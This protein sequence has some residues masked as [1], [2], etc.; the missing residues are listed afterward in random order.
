MRE[1]GRAKTAWGCMGCLT[2]F[3]AAVFVSGLVAGLA[4]YLHERMGPGTGDRRVADPTSQGELPVVELMIDADRLGRPVSPLIY[5]SNLTAKTEYEMDVARFAR[6]TGIKIFRYPGSSSEGYHWKE[7]RFDFNSRFNP[8]PMTRFDKVLKFCRIAGAGLVLQVNIESGTPEEA[9]DWVRFMNRSGK[10]PRVVYWELGNEV[11]GDWDRNHMSGEAYAAVIRR[12][13]AAMKAVDPGIEIGAN[14]AGPNDPFFDEA[15]LRGAAGDIDF[16]S[17]HWYP[18]HTNPE[19]PSGGSKHP[20]PEAVMGNAPAVEELVARVDRILSRVA[21][22]RVG[23]I[24]VA[25]LEWDGS[26]DAPASDPEHRGRGV[27]WSLA[28]AIFYADALGRFARHG[29]ILA[30]Q[31]DFQEGMFGLI[32]GWDR[33][34]GWGG[35]RWD[36]RT[37]RPKALAL[38]LFARHFGDRLVKTRLTG[39]PRYDHETIDLRADAFRGEV[40][41]V[42]AYGSWRT[43]D[44]TLAVAVV[45]K[46]AEQDFALRVTVKGG[47][48]GSRGAAWILSGPSLTAQNDGAPGTVAIRGYRMELDPSGRFFYR[49]PARSVTMLELPLRPVS[50]PGGGK[51]PGGG[52]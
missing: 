37:I 11:Y 50:H 3:L 43:K 42:T 34:A 25:F 29:V 15:V 39:S 19:H 13:S 46:H 36:G 9:A 12:F 24:A 21:P 26:W 52:G 16:V 31:Y 33:Q 45:N 51:G 30:A 47:R 8:A 4:W 49:V 41:Y 40:P 38:R 22:G 14:L 28:D 1:G 27:M 5:G 48:L 18:N 17:Y 7:G 23:R 20:S 2:G 10:G 35:E 44:N 32:S 6:D